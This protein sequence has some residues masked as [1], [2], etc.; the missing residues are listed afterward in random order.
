MTTIDYSVYTVKGRGMVYNY[1]HESGPIGRSR[2]LIDKTYII[3]LYIL[4]STKWVFNGKIKDRVYKQHTTSTITTCTSKIVSRRPETN[5]CV[6]ISVKSYCLQIEGHV[7]KCSIKD[8]WPTYTFP[9]QT[10]L[11]ILIFREKPA[12]TCLIFSS[13]HYEYWV[14]Y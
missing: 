6:I 14:V 7:I 10:F 2:E 12:W 11:H 5:H 9:A 4:P 13:Q 3:I 1:N 8:I